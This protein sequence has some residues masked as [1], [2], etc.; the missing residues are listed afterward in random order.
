MVVDSRPGCGVAKKVGSCCRQKGKVRRA[1]SHPAAR[2]AWGRRA[3]AGTVARTWLPEMV[4][5]GQACAASPQSPSRFHRSPGCPGEWL[6]RTCSQKLCRQGLI[7]SQPSFPWG[8]STA[9]IK[10]VHFRDPRFVSALASDH[11][12]KSGIVR[13]IIAIGSSIVLD[14]SACLRFWFVPSSLLPPSQHFH[15]STV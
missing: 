3:Q 12:F 7:L 13:S 2:L 10:I 8:K 15:P 6:A 14:S 9:T 5:A 4:K 11:G 1:C